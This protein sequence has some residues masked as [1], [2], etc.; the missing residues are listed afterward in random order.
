MQS[1][2]VDAVAA[3]RYRCRFNFTL[4]GFSSLLSGFPH[5]FRSVFRETVMKIFFNIDLMK[6][7][8]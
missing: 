6:N 8:S 3:E 7:L 5:V 4:P 1:G 2:S